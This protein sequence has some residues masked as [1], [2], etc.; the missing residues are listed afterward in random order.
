MRVISLK[1][2]TSICLVMAFF[3]QTVIA[4]TS[5]SFSCSANLVV[6]LDNGYHA[7][8]DGDFSFTDGSL[9]N[10]MS[11]SLTAGG[12]LNIGVNASLD[13]PFISLSSNDFFI[14][15]TLS[16]PD[17][18]IVISATNS[19]AIASS[20]QT[21]IAGSTVFQ[22]APKAI[23]GGNALNILPGGS[24][25]LGT[26]NTSSNVL[27]GI[28]NQSTY[29]LII[30]NVATSNGGSILLSNTNG[31]I[32]PTGIVVGNNLSLD[33]VTGPSLMVSNVPEPSSYFILFLGLFVLTFIIKPKQFS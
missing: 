30:R 1:I 13:A 29:K 26:I 31:V 20:A 19:I 22:T 21:N 25:S 27:N 17:G 10:D 6:S 18:E 5:P 24:L 11:I 3:S 2:I 23:I 8:C 4:T 14:G 9:Q 32:F 16:A 15:G 7:S 28:S 12:F 33:A